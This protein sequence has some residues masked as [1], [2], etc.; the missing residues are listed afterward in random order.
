MS[1]HRRYQTL[2]NLKHLS[3]KRAKQYPA[4]ERYGPN[5]FE[6]LF[7]SLGGPPNILCRYN[8]S[9]ERLHTS[10]EF[11]SHLLEGGVRGH[12]SPSSHDGGQGELLNFSLPEDTSGSGESLQPPFG[13]SFQDDNSQHEAPCERLERKRVDGRRDRRGRMPGEEDFFSNGRV[14]G[15]GARRKREAKPIIQ[16]KKELL[17]NRKAKRERGVGGN[18]KVWT[19]DAAL[20]GTRER[21]K[22][23]MSLPLEWP[24]K[25]IKSFVS[26][27]FSFH[28]L[29]MKVFLLLKQV[30]LFLFLFM[31]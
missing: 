31:P 17:K 4:E 2:P 1:S 8:K 22:V 5:Y 20:T 6:G 21:E 15:R 3:R 26:I 19:G 28:A 13:Y 18:E 30:F 11:T 29:R 24:T 27:Y 7:T 9:R 10:N 14:E 12:R 23:Q 25:V 16:E